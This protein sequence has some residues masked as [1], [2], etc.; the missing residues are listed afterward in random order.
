MVPSQA[1]QA[2]QATYVF[3]LPDKSLSLPH[4]EAQL[5]SYFRAKRLQEKKVSDQA[6]KIMFNE[7][8][9]T[10]QKDQ[11]IQALQIPCNKCKNGATLTFERRGSDLMIVCSSGN[12][13]CNKTIHRGEYTT[14]GILQSQVRERI[15]QLKTT[16]VKLRLEQ[17][18]GLIGKDEAI[19]EFEKTRDSLALEEQSLTKLNDMYESETQ[20]TERKAKARAITVQLQ[21]E[22][23]A[24]RQDLRVYHADG[25]NDRLRAA[26]DRY[27]ESVQP[28]STS[29]RETEYR[30]AFTAK[31]GPDVV[32][33]EKKV[34]PEELQVS[35]ST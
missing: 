28:L 27:G 29:L 8:L 30:E 32:L 25:D 21:A 26:V 33:I 19:G 12:P 11:R 24:V 14:I 22:I 34:T 9:S 13:R 3:R 5:H 16:I 1:C 31:L 35:L 18:H 15:R 23:D 6:K 17:M 7:H 4:M 10:A 20:S 2:L